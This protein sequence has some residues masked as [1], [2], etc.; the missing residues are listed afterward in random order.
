[1]ETNQPT[2]EIIEKQKLT[3]EEIKMM[4]ELKI[5]STEKEYKHISSMIK[6]LCSDMSNIVF[7]DMREL[8][9]E[10]FLENWN[11]IQNDPENIKWSNDLFKQIDEC[12]NQHVHIEKGYNDPNHKEAFDDS[13]KKGLEQV[14]KNLEL[15]IDKTKEEI[16]L[17][18]KTKMIGALKK[19]S[20]EEEYMLIFHMRSKSSSDMSNIVFADMKRFG[21]STWLTEW[22]SIQDNPNAK[23]KDLMADMYKESEQYK[24]EH[25]ERGYDDPNYKILFGDSVKMH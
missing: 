10:K 8:G 15:E 14:F 9:V 21:V 1:M 6:D 2:Q 22:R 19:I 12:R 23:Y 11:Q 20:T 3:T 24:N 7:A 13:V 16:S 4:D 25:I 5:I 18:E 17:G